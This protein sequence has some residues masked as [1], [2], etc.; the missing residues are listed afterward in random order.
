MFRI[1]ER[2]YL[3]GVY[4]DGITVYKQQIRALNIFHALVRTGVIDRA[5]TGYKIGV[6][7]GGVAGLTFAAASLKAGMKVRLFEKEP[8]FLHMQHG[9]DI[10]T[11]HPN[12]YEWPDGNS[13]F[14]YADVPVLP[15]KHDTASNVAKQII[16]E[17]EKVR[18]D[19]EKEAGHDAEEYFREYMNATVNEIANKQ[20]DGQD[21]IVVK[22]RTSPRVTEYF[23]L[24][25]FAVGYGVERGLRA[26]VLSYWRNDPFGQPFL[27]DGKGRKKHQIFIVSG[28][29]DGGLMDLF[30]LTVLGFSLSGFLQ[31]LMTHAKYDRLVSKLA[32]VKAACLREKNLTP[33]F[34]HGRFSD[35]AESHYRFIVHEYLRPNLRQNITVYLNDKE[36]EF[37]DT[38]DFKKISLLNAFLAFLLHREGFVEYRGGQIGYNAK[39]KRYA[40]GPDTLQ[41]DTECVAII[42]HGT[43]KNAIFS[44][45]PLSAA[46]KR[47]LRVIRE[48]QQQSFNYGRVQ[49]RWTYPELAA[50]LNGKH[51]KAKATP[52]RPRYGYYT[53]DT[54]AL[55]SGFVSIVAGVIEN[56]IPKGKIFRASL[57][58]LLHTGTEL[59]FQQITP[60]F[61]TDVAENNRETVGRIFTLDRGIVGLS[62]KTGLPLL[63]KNEDETETA[64]MVQELQLQ[65]EVKR[66]KSRRSF[67]AIPV[68]APLKKTAGRKP[69]GI[70][71]NLVIFID[72]NSEE[73]FTRQM[74]GLIVSAAKGF[75][76]SVERL[77][78][79][80]QVVMGQ[81]NFEPAPVDPDDPSLVRLRTARS[82]QDLSSWKEHR[83]LRPEKSVLQFTDFYTFD[84]VYNDASP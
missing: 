5:N 28:V 33:Q 61:G 36:A 65:K 21:K 37:E 8:V 51:P 70:A 30:R 66:L 72:S 4:Q 58:R 14:P 46:D 62:F 7:G 81:R 55:C 39:T 53:R 6:I 44:N 59:C 42:R 3:I 77:V 13:F 71:A 16:G 18:L 17:F 83:Q 45:L 74:T 78:R 38:L 32:Q 29:G 73:F 67:L 15:W 26:D 10:R 41:T 57:H 54:V 43:N 40:F 24:L 56:S 50:L 69:P 76:G 1:G 49:K 23:D 64:L 80:G 31:F 48:K 68:L 2:K 52:V 79:E 63:V 60:Y 12:I 34:L 84:I 35:L 22:T 11:I 27:T 75:I 25:V 20:R 19:L 47:Q 82:L 9:C